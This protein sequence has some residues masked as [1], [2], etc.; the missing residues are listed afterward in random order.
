M[1]VVLLAVI[2]VLVAFMIVQHQQKKAR[3]KHLVYMAKKINSIL[4]QD[5]KEQLLLMTDDQE[6]R[7]LLVEINL[8]LDKQHRERAMF[9]KSRHSMKRMLANIS[10]DLKT[11]LTVVLGY[12]ET[13]KNDQDVPFK[14]RERRLRHVEKKTL[15]I[16]KFMNAFFDLAKL[17]S[18]DKQIQ[19]TK[20]NMIE[21]CK[22]N[23]LSFYDFVE[24]KGIE[25]DLQLPEEP[26]Y[27]L[28]NKEALDRVLHNLL[29]NAIRH[30]GDGNVIGLALFYDDKQVYIEVWDKGKGIAEQ[31]QD[32]VFE[33]MFTLEESR[34]KAFQGSGLGLTI[35]KRLVEKMNGKIHLHSIPNEK[36]TFTITFKRFT[37]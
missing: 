1:N 2:C 35:T 27:V 13:L 37:Y 28:G 5:S 18:G 24:A 26:V 20:I 14:E 3:N 29:S 7:A 6:L 34:N 15:E 32:Q 33:R 9:E 21:V 30:G 4:S 17:E 25:V 31:E 22:Q 23:I 12:I 8:L 16:I 10:H 19:L 36:T 11:P